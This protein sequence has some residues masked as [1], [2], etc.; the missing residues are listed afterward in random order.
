M[1]GNVLA[2][3]YQ[4]SSLKRDKGYSETDHVC[5]RGLYDHR[6]E[7]CWRELRGSGTI[8]ARHDAPS[9]ADLDHL[10]TATNLVSH[11]FDGF[12]HPICQMKR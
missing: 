6:F 8:D 12:F 4:S 1:G 10:G 11:G 2:D 7:L 9:R 3:E 5:A